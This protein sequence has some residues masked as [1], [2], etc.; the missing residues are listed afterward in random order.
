MGVCSANKKLFIL[1]LKFD[2]DDHQFLSKIVN[3]HDHNQQIEMKY[4]TLSGRKIN[5]FKKKG[6]MLFHM[7]E[8]KFKFQSQNWAILDLNIRKKI[9]T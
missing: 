4:N 1:M 2:F 3:Q 7:M 6:R 9:S 5:T 8:S